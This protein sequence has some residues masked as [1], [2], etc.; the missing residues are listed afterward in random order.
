MI[1]DMNEYYS[2]EKI[3]TEAIEGL[4]FSACGI[5]RISEVDTVAADAF[6][7]WLGQGC[8]ADMHYMEGYEDK[9]LNPRLLMPEAKTMIC[10]ALSYAPEKTDGDDTIP[11]LSA[12]ARGKDYHDV[13]KARM[14]ELAERLGLAVY[15]VFCDTAPI[16][17]RYWAEKAGLGWIGRNHQ[18]IVPKAGSM[19]FLGEIFTD[20]EVDAFDVPLRSHC[21]ADCRRCI[22]ACPTGALQL[23]AP[24]DARRCLSFHTIE[25][26]GEIPDEIAEKM[27]NCFYGCDRCQNA[28]PWNSHSMPTEVDEFRPSEALKAMTLDDWRNL[29][30]EDYRR[31]FK[32]SAVKRAKYEGLMRNISKIK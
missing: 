16:L 9:R 2:A 21:G 18:L 12:Y 7:K 8:N 31:L 11:Y 17:E 29:S 26:R 22:D 15:R 5:V 14:R 6:R 23:D 28:C 20:V 27:G 24:L 25:N 1:G 13:M 19:F 4:G 3:K 30:V 32:G 10:L